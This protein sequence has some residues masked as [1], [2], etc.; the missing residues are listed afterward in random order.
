[1][2]LL[3]NSALTRL[4]TLG[5]P[6]DHDGQRHVLR[7]HPAVGMRDWVGN[8]VFFDQNPL[9]SGYL[10]TPAQQKQFNRALRSDQRLLR[11]REACRQRL[12][13]FDV[14]HNVKN[15][16]F[17]HLLTATTSAEENLEKN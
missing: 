17:D 8:C 16:S 11:Y 12:E 5:M 6:H 10:L 3:H 9:F 2:P 13:D 14:Q 15:G 7:S 1:M 4:D